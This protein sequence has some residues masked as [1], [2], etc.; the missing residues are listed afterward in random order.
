MKRKTILIRF[1]LPGS[2]LV[3]GMIAFSCNVRYDAPV[4]SDWVFVNKTTST[5][6]VQDKIFN[7]FVLQPDSTYIFQESGEGPD[8]IK[9]EGYYSPYGASSTIIVDD[10][11]RHILSKGESIS[12]VK[13]YKA[14]KV[15]YNYYRFTYIFTRDSIAW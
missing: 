1:L 3:V 9:P 2:L 13:N 4:S 15:G 7:S 5:I 11:I 6:E 10:T 8:G 14:E 12:N